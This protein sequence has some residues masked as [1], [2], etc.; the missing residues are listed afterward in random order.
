MALQF[1]KLGCSKGGRQLFRNLE[2]TI[3]MGAW[4]YVKGA[5]GVGKTSLLRMVS[6]LAAIESGDVLWN[7]QSIQ[8]HA[9]DYRRALRFLGHLNCLQDAMTVSENLQYACALH[10]GR[11]D[12][13]QCKQ[14]LGAFGLK[15]R[16]SQ[17]ARHLS[18]G[19]RRR[20][21]L[22]RLALSPGRL[23]VLDEP[24][25]AMDEAGIK[26]LSAM[27]G[28]HLDGGGAAIIT[29]HQEVPVERHA[30]LILELS[31]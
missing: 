6:G 10:G 2:R 22:A 11:L 23:W 26:L 20:V 4:M 5:N 27:V 15:G 16:E 3:P 1:S 28:Q 7:G 29:S 12:E 19:Q 17:L 9:E 14:T 30:P 8:S 13:V 24:Y 21:A 18:Q 25:V 31:A